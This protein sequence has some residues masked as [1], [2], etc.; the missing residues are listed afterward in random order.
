[1]PLFVAW[2]SLAASL[3]ALLLVDSASAQCS[4]GFLPG[5]ERSLFNGDVLCSTTW[6]PDGDGPLSEWLVVGGTFTIVGQ[7]SVARIAAWDGMKWRSLG[8]GL[9]DDV[10]AL[11]VYDGRL[12]AAGDFLVAGGQSANRIAQYDGVSWTALGA[13]VTT[14]GTGVPAIN[15][16]TVHQGNLIAGG[17]FATAGLVAATNIARWNGN[18]WSG[19]AG[20]LN[21]TV[22]ALV[23]SGNELVAAGTMTGG[24]RALESGLWTE[25]A[26]PLSG[27]SCLA[28]FQ[29]ELYAGGSFVSTTGAA[30][31][32]PLPRIARLTPT[33]WASPGVGVFGTSSGTIPVRSL[34]AV[35]DRL[36]VGGSF[37]GAGTL[38][39]NNIAAWDGQQWYAYGRGVVSSSFPGGEVFT[40]AE[41]GGRLVAAGRFTSSGRGTSLSNVAAWGGEE[42]MPLTPSP[43]DAVLAATEW[44]G[45]LVLGGEFT[46]FGS[47]ET[48]R[49]TSWNGA[50]WVSV[51]GGVTGSD[52]QALASFEDDLYAGGAFTGAGGRIVANIARWDGTEW[53]SVGGGIAG[54]GTGTRVTAMVNFDGELIV[55][56]TFTSAGPIAAVNAAAWNGVSWRPLANS[57][58]GPLGT[59]SLSALVVHQGSLYAS[60]SSGVARFDGQGWTTLMTGAVNVISLAT[61]GNRLIAGGSFSSIGGAGSRLVAAWNGTAWSALGQG[62]TGTSSPVVHAV[63]VYNGR[64]YATGQFAFSGPISTTG[65][66]RFSDA[67]GTWEPLGPGLG[68]SFTGVTGIGRALVPYRGELLVAGDFLAAG[69]QPS[70]GWARY[71]DSSLPRIVRQPIAPTFT[72]GGTVQISVGIDAAYSIFGATTFQWRRNGVAI[73]DGPQPGN[74]GNPSIAA[75]SS[76]ATLT[77]S[78]SSLT[79]RGNYDCVITN[80]CGSVTSGAVMFASVVCRAD[81]NSDGSATLQD[82]FDFLTA[83]FATDPRADFNMNSEVTVQD[84]LDFLAAWFAG[85]G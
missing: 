57:V 67:T 48:G 63:G 42:W 79:D 22:T 76:S 28:Y 5:M 81:F 14:G 73:A 56:G 23:A 44:N 66:A 19:I 43:N 55:A 3:C 64:I 80:P 41:S 7:A 40:I 37:F 10:R 26:S 71:T 29:G 33:G 2:R 20:G 12:V 9:D 77:I 83:W 52:V 49:I 51:G 61:D 25:I 13:G 78:N 32:V 39:C 4:G 35:G 70:A 21:G 30:T 59:S 17:T 45:Q 65:I 15:A 82:I 58:T 75:G 31:T 36:V 72:P 47:L 16:L 62:L 74:P 1:M 8:S 50:E 38:V 6:D 53:H 54:I 69:T 11:T 85:C 60:G 68:T 27:V 24:V 34:R 84:L 18:V 46:S